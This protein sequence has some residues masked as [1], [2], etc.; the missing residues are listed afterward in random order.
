MRNKDAPQINRTI[1]RNK[2]EQK[3]FSYFCLLNLNIKLLCYMLAEAKAKVVRLGLFDLG[4]PWVMSDL[5]L[6]C[7]QINHIASRMPIALHKRYLDFIEEVIP[8]VMPENYAK[9]DGVK[10]RDDESNTPVKNM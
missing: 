6:C 1:M 3:H 7:R 8:D 2:D 5:V 4:T 10:L 9:L